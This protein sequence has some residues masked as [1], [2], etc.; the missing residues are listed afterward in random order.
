MIH[1]NEHIRNSPGFL[2]DLFL[3][4]TYHARNIADFLKNKETIKPTGMTLPP[5]I[6]YLGSA[7]VKF[8]IAVFEK[9]DYN[10]GRLS[11]STGSLDNIDLE[12]FCVGER[13]KDRMVMDDIYIQYRPKDGHIWLHHTYKKPSPERETEKEG[14][15]L[16][17]PLIATS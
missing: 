12:F 4:E 6:L 3:Q 1:L 13:L 5:G 8:P 16:T 11:D 10:F 7:L 17:E 14:W 9:V 2:L 15:L